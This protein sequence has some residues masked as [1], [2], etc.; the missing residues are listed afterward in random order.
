MKK[1]MMMIALVGVV[2][3]ATAQDGKEATKKRQLRAVVQKTLK[4]QALQIKSL[5]PKACCGRKESL[6]QRWRQS[7][8]ISYKTK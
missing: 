2:S 5:L 7:K 8:S 4:V 3:F 6:L 1:L